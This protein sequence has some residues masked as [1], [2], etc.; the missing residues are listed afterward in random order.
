[1]ATTF[2]LHGKIG[3][4]SKVAKFLAVSTF[5]K[6]KYIEAGFR[7]E[8]IAVKPNFA[9]PTDVREGAGDYFLFAGRLSAE[10]GVATLLKAWNR[11]LGRLVIVGDGPEAP[12]LKSAAPDDVE[13]R[14]FVD[15]AKMPEI[16]RDARAL[17]LPSIWYE[18]QP[19]I[20]LEAYAAGVPVIASEIGGLPELVTDGVTGFTVPA[21]D[22]EAWTRALNRLRDDEVAKRL[23][24][25][26]RA[27]WRK[28]YSPESGLQNLMH[29]YDAVAPR[30][31]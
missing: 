28:H 5:V 24:N 11:S 12:K 8:S 22:A 7:R 15:G 26:A 18:A 30:M 23:G 25:K 9:W 2:T 10:K 1:M 14:G 16:L 21:Q 17:L 6:E 31:S 20:I 29:A 3:T 19:R 4:F 13:F 27:R